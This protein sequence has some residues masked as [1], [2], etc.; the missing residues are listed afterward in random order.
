MDY[1][2]YILY[3]KSINRYYV[4]YTSDIIERIKLHNSST[5]GN[6]SY[7]H[8]TSDWELFLLI[9]CANIEQAVFIESKIKGMKSKV[10]IQNLKKYPEIIEKIRKEYFK[11]LN[12]YH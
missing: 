10:Y 4:G 6:K 9:E 2:C 12:I 8:C 7:T 3:S 11:Q 5:F 1:S